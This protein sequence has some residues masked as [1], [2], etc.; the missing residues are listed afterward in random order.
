M[1]EVYI[2]YS[3]MHVT[4]FASD[5]LALFHSREQ[6]ISVGVE[7]KINNVAML[8]SVDPSTNIKFS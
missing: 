7:E 6:N 2:S 3:M 8:L 4:Y 1:Q 5:V